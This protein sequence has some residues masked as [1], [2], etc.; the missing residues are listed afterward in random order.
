MKWFAISACSPNAV[1]Q[2]PSLPKLRTTA[3][4]MAD[5]FSWH[6]YRLQR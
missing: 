3:L 2:P 1:G 5:L 4:Q 6:T